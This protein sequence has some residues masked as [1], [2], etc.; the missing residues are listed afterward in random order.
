MRGKCR[1]TRVGL[2]E[3]ATP[4]NAC[5]GDP[6]RKTYLK[7]QALR[8]TAQGGRCFGNV[9]I[10]SLTEVVRSIEGGT[11]KSGEFEVA[12]RVALLHWRPGG[13]RLGTLTVFER[14]ETRWKIIPLR[15]VV[16]RTDQG[17][18]PRHGAQAIRVHNLTP[19]SF[20]VRR[21]KG[22]GDDSRDHQ[23]VLETTDTRAIVLPGQS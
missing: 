2:A 8:G 9:S 19:K 22:R 11:V 4:E 20:G 23:P 13:M 14:T 15:D 18:F 6:A 7:P 17:A 5:H 3:T 10:K 21:A 12:E 16:T 1:G